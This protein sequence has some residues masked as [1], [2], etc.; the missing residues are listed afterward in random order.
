M[1]TWY[2]PI[3]SQTRS[4]GR[5]YTHRLRTCLNFGPFW[6]LAGS[7]L[8]LC[9]LSQTQS[10]PI[11]VLKMCS[12]ALTKFYVLTPPQVNPIDICILPVKNWARL[13][14]SNLTSVSSSWW[15]LYLV[16]TWGMCTFCSQYRI[17][18]YRIF[19]ARYAFF[20]F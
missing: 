17:S 19:L 20:S 18:V 11:Y 3:G 5:E 2:W 7:S 15:M 6:A 9:N 4:P 16:I 14:I 13:S 12:L 8:H 1:H 10:V